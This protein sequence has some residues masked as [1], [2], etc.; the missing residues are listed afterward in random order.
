MAC[1][2]CGEPVVLM[3]SAE[4]RARR[5]NDHPAAYYTA[6]FPDHVSCVIKNNTDEVHKL[7]NRI[8]LNPGT[9]T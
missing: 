5:Y 1:K 7:M 8:T 6:L 2:Y 3:P 9:Q 4:Q